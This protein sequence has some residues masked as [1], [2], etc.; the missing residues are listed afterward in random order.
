VTL[1]YC[2]ETVQTSFA[3]PSA[4]YQQ[5]RDQLNAE[6]IKHGEAILKKYEEK[7]KEHSIQHKVELLKG[8]SAKELLVSYTLHNDV[9]NLV[10][11][12]RSMG[13]VER[14][15]VGSTTDYCALTNLLDFVWL[16]TFAL[17]AFIMPTAT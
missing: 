6:A 4:Y 10:L 12:R 11:G 3:Q 17:Q 7:L 5:L 14:K 2:N 8:D 15:L 9:D 1:V 16:T 13:K